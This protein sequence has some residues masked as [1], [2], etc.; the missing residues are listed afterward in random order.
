MAWLLRE[1]AMD[2]LEQ[3]QSQLTQL[4]LASR[5]SVVDAL[6]AS[7]TNELEQMAIQSLKEDIAICEERLAE[8]DSGKTQSVTWGEVCN[9]VFGSQ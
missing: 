1:Q 8:L 2:N 5:I 9:R 6:E 4:P 3:I 7:I